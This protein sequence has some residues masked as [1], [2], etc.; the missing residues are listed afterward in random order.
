MGTETAQ[1]VATEQTRTIDSYSAQ[2]T[3]GMHEVVLPNGTMR[4]NKELVRQYGGIKDPLLVHVFSYVHGHRD[5]V[6]TDV[7]EAVVTEYDL[8][9]VCPEGMGVQGFIRTDSGFNRNQRAS[10]QACPAPIIVHENDARWS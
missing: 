10:I 4:A 3:F 6:D 8:A 1:M 9:V 7:L 2:D 5:T